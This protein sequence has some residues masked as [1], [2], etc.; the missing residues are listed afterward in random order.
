MPFVGFVSFF[1]TVDEL[2]SLHCE[3]EVKYYNLGLDSFCCISLWE[4]AGSVPTKIR[5]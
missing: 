2:W 4:E 1:S 5:R 3:I